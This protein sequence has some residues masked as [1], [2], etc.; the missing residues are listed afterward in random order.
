[1]TTL[2]LEQ[3]NELDNRLDSIKSAIADLQSALWGLDNMDVELSGALLN[4]FG[5]G[6]FADKLD[7]AL[8]ELVDDLSE[9]T[10]IEFTTD[11]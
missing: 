6:E 9:N 7:D 2:T 1:M 3:Q 10:G 11:Y 4:S 8:L 5:A